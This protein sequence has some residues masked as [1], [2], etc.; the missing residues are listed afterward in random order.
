M[1]MHVLRTSTKRTDAY[2]TIEGWALGL[3]I[4]VHAV[5]ECHEH[6]FYRDLGDPEALRNAKEIAAS[7][8]FRSF[9]PVEAILAIEKVMGS[10]GD[11]CPVCH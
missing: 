8:P 2:Q 6:G 1:N 4:E 10:I 11:T 9:S 3:L 7:E 5:A